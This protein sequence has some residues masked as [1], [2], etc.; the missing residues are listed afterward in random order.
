VVQP[1]GLLILLHKLLRDYVNA[2][3][4]CCGVAQVGINI[5]SFLLL[6]LLLLLLRQLLSALM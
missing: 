3:S 6:L 2:C 4:C 5:M 1:S